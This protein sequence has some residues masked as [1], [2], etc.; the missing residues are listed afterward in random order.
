MNA[1]VE[2]MARRLGVSTYELFCRARSGYGGARDSPRSAWNL[3][4]MCGTVPDFVLRF[5]QQQEAKE[6]HA[7][8]LRTTGS[9]LAVVNGAS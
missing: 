5:I 2:D 9:R 1:K 6:S 8:Y 7:E 4:Q 3:Y